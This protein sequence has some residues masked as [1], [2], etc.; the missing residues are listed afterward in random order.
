MDTSKVADAAEKVVG[1][2]PSAERSEF[3]S[4]ITILMVISILVSI[5]RIIQECKKS[6]NDVNGMA[7]KLSILDKRRVRQQVKQ[8]LKSSGAK[9]D[10]SLTNAIIEYGKSADL[11]EL[12][13]VFDM[14]AQS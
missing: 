2:I 8:Q 11:D 9:F 5:A 3:K 7:G 13:A 6:H 1:F 12:K 4:I 14:A 10:K